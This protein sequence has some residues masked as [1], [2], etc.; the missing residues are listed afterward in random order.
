LSIGLD[1]AIGVAWRHKTVHT[2]RGGDSSS[3]FSAHVGP[4]IMTADRRG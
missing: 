1:G 3:Y 2:E 4:D